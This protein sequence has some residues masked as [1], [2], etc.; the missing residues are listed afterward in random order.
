MSEQMKIGNIDDK[1][2]VHWMTG[3]DHV[4]TWPIGQAE[5]ERSNR[6]CKVDFEAGTD[7]K[8]PNP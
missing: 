3:G 6:R 2:T 1:I 8:L 4:S 7:I 5:R